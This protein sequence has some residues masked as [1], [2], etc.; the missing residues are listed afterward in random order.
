VLVESKRSLVAP[1]L[2]QVRLQLAQAIGKRELAQAVQALV[3]AA[4][5]E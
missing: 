1:K 3:N 2:E 5:I 4:K